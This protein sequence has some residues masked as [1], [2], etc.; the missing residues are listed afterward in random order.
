MEENEIEDT[1]PVE[2]TVPLEGTLPLEDTVVL[3]NVAVLETQLVED[4]KNLEQRLLPLGERDGDAGADNPVDVINRQG[5][6]GQRLN[7]WKNSNQIMACL[8]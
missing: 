2:D 4:D 3:E 7:Y 8:V 5:D 1:L 6:T